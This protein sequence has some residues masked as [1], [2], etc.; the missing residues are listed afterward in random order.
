[1]M[2]NGRAVTPRTGTPDILSSDYGSDFGDDDIADQNSETT[3]LM[4]SSGSASKSRADKKAARRAA[5]LGGASA[6]L[7]QRVLQ[8]GGGFSQNVRRAAA[9]VVSI[10]ILLIAVYQGFV[11]GTVLAI[12]VGSL[13]TALYITRWVLSQPEGPR[14]F[15]N[16]ADAIREGSEA[17]FSRVYGTIARLAIPMGGVIFCLY[18]FRHPSKDTEE[19]D[20][21]MLAI[22]TALSFLAGAFCSGLAGYI[23][24]WTSVRANVRVAY[25]A[26]NSYRG[27]I[28]VALRGRR[29]RRPLRC[30]ACRFGRYAAILPV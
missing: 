23:G 27:T 7:Q 18:Y 2:D 14:G 9:A 30:H 16:I 26:T 10:L 29:S 22:L 8:E 5:K 11:L 12:C 13:A 25:A 17:F 1:M 20:Q 19:L 3:G 6:R 24:L 4:S 28:Q 21:M 15:T